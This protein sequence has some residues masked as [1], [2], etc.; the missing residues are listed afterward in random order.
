[1][2]YALV[3]AAGAISTSASGAAVT[4]AW[5]TGANRTAGNLLLCLVAST[6]TGNSPGSV[7]GWTKQTATVGNSAA[8]SAFVK[9]ATGGDAA[10]TVPAVTSTVLNV[11]LYEFS[12]N[13]ASAASDQLQTGFATTTPRVLTCPNV[14]ATAGELVIVI[15]AALNSASRANTLTHTVNNGATITSTNNNA[16]ST[17]SHYNIGYGVT[18]SNASATSDSLAFGTTQLTEVDALLLTFK[19][20]PPL[21][22]LPQF[23]RR[24]VAP[25]NLTPLTSRGRF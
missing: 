24:Q 15:G 7:S 23:H 13:S 6:G 21:T 8:A 4:P 12:G 1:M 2:A 19:L 14:D 10:P 3:G 9:L 17:T 5:G 25:V 18:T 16:T 11:Q 20:A 22:L